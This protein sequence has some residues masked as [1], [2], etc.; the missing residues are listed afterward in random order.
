[1]KKSPAAS[2][3]KSRSLRQVR[4]KPDYPLHGTELDLPLKV[5]LD[6]SKE[7]R[8]RYIKA[9]VH[10]FKKLVKSDTMALKKRTYFAAEMRD[11]RKLFY[12]PADQYLFTDDR[13]GRRWVMGKGSPGSTHVYWSRN[14]IWKMKTKGGSLQEQILTSSPKLIRS[15]ERFL[16][17]SVSSKESLRNTRYSAVLNIIQFLQYDKSSGCAFPPFHAKFLA[18]KYLP[19]DT[20]GL[21]V[22]PCAGW[23]G[24]LIGTLL[25]NRPHHVRYIGIDPEERNREAY[26]GLTRRATIWLKD[27][28]RAPRDSRIFYKPFEDW[29]ATKPAKELYGKVDL[30]MTS[31]PYF[32]AENYNPDNP[33]QSANRYDQYRIWR[34]RFYR[35]LIRGAFDLLKPGGHFVLNIADVAEAPSLERDASKMAKEEGFVWAGFFKLA[36]SMTPTTRKAGNARH[37]VSVNGKQFKHEPV[38]VFKKPTT[39]ELRNSAPAAKKVQKPKVT[40][41]ARSVNRSG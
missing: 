34:E 8:L 38:F 20:A 26:E 13:N 3:K 36:M 30:V 35:K 40:A 2:G 39:T 28:I 5:I 27:E 29:I 10:E 16:D 25:V 37:V 1:M 12:A 15:L 24:R 7:K 9:V 17:P 4:V 33:N 41:K 31:P 11:L 19:R 32:G 6:L 22:D 14:H 23:G 21:V 18:D